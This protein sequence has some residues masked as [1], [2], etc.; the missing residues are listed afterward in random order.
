VVALAG[1]DAEGVRGEHL[2]R[3]ALEGDPD[4]L[5]VMREFAWWVALGLANLATLLDT[6]VM[7]IGGG[8]VAAGPLLLDPTR[9]AFAEHLLGG[10]HRP[11]V[12][13]VLAALGPDAGAIG[14]ACL[15]ADLASDPHGDRAVGHP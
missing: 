10:S 12:R 6:E 2:T 1:G 15:A 9:E 7:V 8:L 11:P 5:E 13:V 14:A 4:A 3:A